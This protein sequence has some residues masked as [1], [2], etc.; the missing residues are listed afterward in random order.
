MDGWRL[1]WKSLF[2]S[3]SVVWFSLSWFAMK[4]FQ[5]GTNEPSLP[6]IHN[7]CINHASCVDALQAQVEWSRL[8][9]MRPWFEKIQSKLF[10]ALWETVCMQM[11]YNVLGV[12]S[13]QSCLHFAGGCCNLRSCW[14]RLGP[15]LVCKECL[16][17]LCIALVVNTFHE[18]VQL[19]VLEL[20]GFNL[21]TGDS[22]ICPSNGEDCCKSERRSWRKVL[23]ETLHVAWYVC[24]VVGSS[25][26]C[27]CFW[28]SWCISPKINHWLQGI[29]KEERT[30]QDWSAGSDNQECWQVMVMNVSAICFHCFSQEAPSTGLEV[31]TW[32]GVRESKAQDICW[33]DRPL[34]GEAEDVWEVWIWKGEAGTFTSY[35]CKFNLD[36]WSI[37][38]M[39]GWWC[40]AK[41]YTE[42]GEVRTL[43]WIQLA[44]L[45][46][47]CFLVVH[48]W[49]C[50]FKE[51]HSEESCVKFF[52]GMNYAC[53]VGN[54]NPRN[55]LPIIWTLKL[56]CCKTA[57][58]SAKK[59][60][61][62]MMR[63][64][65]SCE[66]CASFCE[67][68]HLIWQNFNHAIGLTATY[69]AWSNLMLLRSLQKA[70]DDQLVIEKDCV[71]PCECGGWWRGC[72]VF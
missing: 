17:L 33:K 53:W 8:V 7:L 49:F 28:C 56:S 54:I 5:G 62:V 71:K 63:G 64:A 24:M 35:S 34:Y 27:C 38:S 10:V 20:G 44:M 65:G 48:W 16:T 3:F 67:C 6:C 1:H 22:S 59:K 37:H 15:N 69:Y 43:T 12:V 72:C 29:Q 47:F 66:K 14:P 4:S 41:F 55:W 13:C 23:W 9:V 70:M 42:Q 30:L 51:G 21:K 61:W 26:C 58:R 52:G 32:H 39:Q 18:R 31:G 19:W 60:W 45:Y 68:L 50:T 46:V 25:C 57:G 40:L 2:P 11:M 36:F